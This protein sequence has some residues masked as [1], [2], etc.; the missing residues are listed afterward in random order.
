[1]CKIAPGSDYKALYT[2]IYMYIHTYVY[3]VGSYYKARYARI[4]KAPSIQE[5][6]TLGPKV[7]RCDLLW[8]I[9]GPQKDSDSTAR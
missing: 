2:C 1:M 4:P 9:R 5:I 6:A 7:C 3:Y 8:A